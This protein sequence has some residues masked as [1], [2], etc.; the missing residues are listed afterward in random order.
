MLVGNRLKVYSQ[1]TV[2][3]NGVVNIG[4]SMVATSDGDLVVGP[5]GELVIAG[6]TVRSHNVELD[7]AA[8]LDLQAGTLHVDG[9]RL[10]LNR[11]SLI[12]GSATG[13]PIIELTNG[14][15]S[16]VT[17]A[18]HIGSTAGANGRTTLRNPGTR[19]E[20]TG[21]GGA[22]TWSPA[23]RV[24]VRWRSLTEPSLTLMTT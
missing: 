17:F 23:F 12:Y 20:N 13:I 14:A 21:G 24:P 7:A 16:D 18:W 22:R 6:G 4:N 2:D 8:T 5:A 1:G 3:N 11:S 19:L 9:G 15:T 10:E